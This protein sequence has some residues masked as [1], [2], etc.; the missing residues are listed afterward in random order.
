M[1]VNHVVRLEIVREPQLRLL[2]TRESG[3]RFYCGEIN[4]PRGAKSMLTRRAKQFDLVVTGDI[5]VRSTP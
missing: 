5:A 3:S 4:T 2:A 1:K